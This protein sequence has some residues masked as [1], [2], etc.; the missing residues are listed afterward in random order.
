MFVETSKKFMESF[1][2]I[3]TKNLQCLL[4]RNVADDVWFQGHFIDLDYLDWFSRYE[5]SCEPRYL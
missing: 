2:E 5:R 1:S 4:Y 3:K